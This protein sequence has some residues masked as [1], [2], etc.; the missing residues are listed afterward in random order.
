[1]EKRPLATALRSYLYIVVEG[2]PVIVEEQNSADA[3]IVRVLCTV[4][5][6]LNID[7]LEQDSLEVTI[8]MP[9][10]FG[11]MGPGCIVH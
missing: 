6:L 4:D 5:I 8:G 9:G 11:N 1:M 2:A 3:F 7:L 10:E